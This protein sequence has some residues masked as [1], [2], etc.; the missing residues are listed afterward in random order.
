MPNHTH[1]DP[2]A[3]IYLTQRNLERFADRIRPPR[4]KP[5]Q[6]INPATRKTSKK[7]LER[8]TLQQSAPVKHT[9]IIKI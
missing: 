4:Q 2:E 3:L 6:S 7:I 1:T 9:V 8:E 5:Y